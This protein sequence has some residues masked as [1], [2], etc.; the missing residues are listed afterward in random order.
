MES[1]YNPLVRSFD[2]GLHDRRRCVTALSS[3]QRGSPMRTPVLGLPATQ[4]SEGPR[5]PQPP[6]AAHA[7]RKASHLPPRLEISKLNREQPARI[8]NLSQR[9][10]V[11]SKQRLRWRPLGLKLAPSPATREAR[12]PTVERT[13]TQERYMFVQVDTC[14]CIC[15]YMHRQIYKH[16]YIYTYMYVYL[17]AKIQTHV[18]ACIYMYIYIHTHT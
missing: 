12:A 15:G 6:E 3:R 9:V 2:H 13:A 14:T 5:K 18:Y 1:L 4:T 16:V 11:S 8:R 17:Y 10:H 7:F